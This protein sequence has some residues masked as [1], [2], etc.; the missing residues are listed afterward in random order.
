MTLYTAYDQQTA[1]ITIDLSFC[2][3]SQVTKRAVELSEAFGLGVDEEKKFIIYDN[4]SFNIKRGSVVAITGSSGSG[5]SLLLNYIKQHLDRYT[6]F[7]TIVTIEDI[8]TSIDRSK[9]LIDSVGKDTSDAI[10]I[11]SMAGL[12]DAYLMLRRY[13]ELSDGQKYRFL[14]AKMIDSN[15]DAWI[16]DEFCSLL[17]R[18]TAKVVAYTM[19]K[20]ARKLGKTLV[21][22]TAH[23]DLLEDLNPD[24]Y[25]HKS[26]GSKVHLKH[27]DIT[28]KHQC[29][30]LSIAKIENGIRDDYK[31]LEQFHYRQG[32]TPSVANVIYK[33]VINQ[34][35][36]GVTVY[37]PPHLDLKPRNLVLPQFRRQSDLKAHI[38]MV[39][40]LFVRIWRVV[41]DPTFRSIGL[42]AKL[43]KETMPLLH[44]PYIETLA[45]MARYNPFFERAGMIK[46]PSELYHDKDKDYLY[47][48]NTLINSGFDL[49]MLGSKRY[50]TSILQR[51]DENDL[52]EISKVVVN[53]F[54]TMKRNNSLIPLIKEGD[55]NAIATALQNH[56]L[57]YVYL[58]W[59]NP[60]FAEY[61]DPIIPKVNVNE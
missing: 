30:L 59:K 28:A 58:I 51:L 48:L 47:A 21:V 29:S 9:S 39:N 18:T 42:G 43:V 45:V 7:G 19:Q 31:A 37:G 50:T 10:S 35:L 15:A 22:A 56:R 36:A 34:E 54:C 1:D 40:Q 27:S 13:A 60:K 41:V 3:K 26:F 20:T 6:E 32:K 23:T 52:M 61:P 25:I 14:L 53:G 38:S 24:M 57:P 12:N 2:S 44:T 8:R 33:A 17:D 11:L 4:F 49:S 16:I 5:K 55:I 46:V